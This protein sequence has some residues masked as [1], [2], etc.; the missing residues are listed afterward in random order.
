MKSL[1]YTVHL[2]YTFISLLIFG[3]GVKGDK[4]V[5]YCAIHYKNTF[6]ALLTV[7]AGVEREESACIAPA[8]PVP[9]LHQTLVPGRY[10]VRI[11]SF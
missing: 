9:G 5:L 8:K 3:A 1:L 7:G 4:P 11:Q 10:S 2:P 6:L